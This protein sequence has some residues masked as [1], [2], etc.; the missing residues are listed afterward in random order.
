MIIRL[1]KANFSSNNIGQYTTE[2]GT[3]TFNVSPSNATA[4]LTCAAMS[5]STKTGTGTITWANIPAGS[6]VSYEVSLSGYNTQKGSISIYGNTSKTVTLSEVG[7][8]TP[9]A[10]PTNYTFTINPNPS[11]ATVTL[12]ASGYTQ[13]G[14]SITVAS[15]TSVSWKV[16]ASGYTEQN[17]T[18]T[19][20]K[21]ESKSITLSAI[22]SEVIKGSVTTTTTSTSPNARI[23]NLTPNG[24]YRYK[25]TT[26]YD[27]TVSLY[28]GYQTAGSSMLTCLSKPVTANTPIEGTFVM[29]K[30]GVIRKSP[31]NGEYAEFKHVF[32]RTLQ[33]TS[34]TVNYELELI[35]VDN[36]RLEGTASFANSG[37]SIFSQR[38]FGFEPGTYSYELTPDYDGKITLYYS[39]SAASEATGSSGY[40]SIGTTTDSIAV[41]SGNKVTG[42]FT[43]PETADTNGLLPD[44]II[45]RSNNSNAVNI[46]YKFTKK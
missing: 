27:G 10:T 19:V 45:I 44:T 17:G 41:T 8:V 38:V 1:T 7:N 26:D 39:Y 46:Q 11:N 40:K 4:T 13:S 21:T 14:N 12:T 28:S 42:E 24:I 2:P 16:S 30:S 25:I 34:A 20:T 31:T 15:G 23:D 43:I 29:T 5:P 37:I 32:V 3:L 6:T 35:G 9:P 36:T 22:N 18:H 33:S